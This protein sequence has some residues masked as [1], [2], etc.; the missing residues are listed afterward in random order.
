MIKNK[1]DYLK[2]KYFELGGHVPDIIKEIFIPD[3]LDN[4]D[5]FLYRWTKLN[6]PKIG[7]TYDGS[8]KGQPL[9][10]YY[11]STHD[12]E[13]K[14]DFSDKNAEFKFEV[15]EFGPYKYI[16]SKET[17][18]LKEM[19]VKNN[20]MSYNKSN[21]IKNFILPVDLE[22][23]KTITDE[24]RNT[25]QF[26][27]KGKTYCS[28]II[29]KNKLRDVDTIQVRF[30]ESA[31]HHV[32]DLKNDLLDLT[33]NTDHLLIVVLGNPEDPK[34][35]WK[36]IGGNH[37]LKAMLGYKLATKAKVLFVPT[38]VSK[39]FNELELEN[40]AFLL[41]RSKKEKILEYNDDDMVQLI[42]KYR[43]NNYTNNSEEV[44][45][46]FEIYHINSKDRAK[47]LKKVSL[48]LK[49]LNLP[50]NWIDYDNPKEAKKLKNLIKKFH[51]PKNGSWACSIKSSMR[52]NIYVTL[53][54]I[55]KYNENKK[56]EDKII[57]TLF[58]FVTH[59]SPKYKED[60]DTKFQK[61]E[62][63]TL[64]WLLKGKVAFHFEVQKSLKAR[65]SII[66][67]K[68]S[69]NNSPNM[70]ANGHTTL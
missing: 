24:I 23:I 28:T 16:V 42:L 58:I 35:L 11:H 18:K 32:Q 31:P 50:V 19:D 63:T 68:K 27:Y 45:K 21:G 40:F 34:S 41:N 54:E 17:K 43:K 65:N 20:P 69:V 44:K 66:N 6:E 26:T 9:V 29:D 64:N 47:I 59:P 33:G 12:R 62:I 25:K 5:S 60:W 4:E 22:K 10:K 14:E 49:N 13:F 48:R 7:K 30:L 2:S 37:S 57:N 38:E 8:R 56:K 15:I 70:A 46:I 39:D 61:D 3:N 52:K 55:A 36:I 67:K 51:D 53:R 1:E